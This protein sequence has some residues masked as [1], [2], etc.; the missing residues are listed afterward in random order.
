MAFTVPID[1]LSVQ[2]SRASGPGGQHVNKTSTRVEVRWNVRQSPSLTEPQRERLL[3]KL[4]NRI[5]SRGAL[6]VVSSSGRSQLRNREVA[7]A[8]L[9]QLVRAALHQ[10]RPRKR[11]KPTRASVE[12]RL[13]EK[14]K[15]SEIKV[16]RRPPKADD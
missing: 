15:R 2:A 11:T 13:A 14:K 8:R 4:A 3:H 9:N 12:Q 5:D 16:R 7:I 10:P 1:E 6:R